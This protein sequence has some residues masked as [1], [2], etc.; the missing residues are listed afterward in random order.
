MIMT[1]DPLTVRDPLLEISAVALPLTFAPIEALISALAASAF[2]SVLALS[3]RAFLLSML[4]PLSFSVIELPF[5]SFRTMP[6][7]L[8]LRVR[9]LPPGVSRIATLS[10]SS[11]RSAILPRETYPFRWLSAVGW[12]GGALALLCS[13]PSTTG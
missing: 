3:L 5:L 2:R 4:M 10:L 12:I 11:N 1:I 7:S 8:S 6:P 9:L 13:M